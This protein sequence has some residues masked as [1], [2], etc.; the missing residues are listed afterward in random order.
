MW[1]LKKKESQD[2]EF[3]IC[4]EKNSMDFVVG[5]SSNDDPLVSELRSE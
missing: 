3:E 4:A 2:R 1:I 5:G